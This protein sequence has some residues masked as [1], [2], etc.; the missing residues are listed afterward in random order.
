MSTLHSLLS[1]ALDKHNKTLITLL[2]QS[3]GL[4]FLVSLTQ[5]CSHHVFRGQI[6]QS[7]NNLHTHTFIFASE[8]HVKITMFRL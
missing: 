3:S 6:N 4:G 1:K 2:K 7:C 8:N 5:E